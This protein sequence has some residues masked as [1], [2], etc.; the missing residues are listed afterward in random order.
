M[1]ISVTVNANDD[2]GTGDQDDGVEYLY[3][4]PKQSVN[5]TS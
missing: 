3:L 4:K 5:K 1:Q 2:H